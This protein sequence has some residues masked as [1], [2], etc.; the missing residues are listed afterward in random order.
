MAIRSHLE[1]NQLLLLPLGTLPY[2]EI[3]AEG[4]ALLLCERGGVLGIPLRFLILVYNTELTEIRCWG[5]M[6]KYAHTL[7]LLNRIG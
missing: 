4:A 1:L 2:S 5:G 6:I 3:L 7:L